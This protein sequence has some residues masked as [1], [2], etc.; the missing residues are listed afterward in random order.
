MIHSTLNVN[1][2]MMMSSNIAEL[3]NSANRETREPPLKK[4]LQLMMDMSMRWNNK[5]ETN[6]QAIL[7]KLGNKYYIIMREH[8]IFVDKM[9]VKTDLLVLL[10]TEQKFATL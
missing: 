10:H 8:L 5:N 6:I 1:R 7:T 9:K 2:S 4:V 3:L